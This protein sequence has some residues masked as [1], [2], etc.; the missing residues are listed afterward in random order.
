MPSP[1]VRPPIERD[2]RRKLLLQHLRIAPPLHAPKLHEHVG[3]TAARAVG[4]D[5]AKKRR[6]RRAALE[7]H[8]RTQG[9]VES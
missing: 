4:G 6:A 5:A 3:H 7:H 9:R 1:V 2:G 8:V